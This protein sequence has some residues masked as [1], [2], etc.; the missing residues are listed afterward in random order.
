MQ[1]LILTG[2][3]GT[4][5]GVTLVNIQSSRRQ[6]GGHL[7]CHSTNFA[8]LQLDFRGRYWGGSGSAWRPLRWPVVRAA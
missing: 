7:P 4:P 1:A 5:R 3:R 2:K 6:K 8:L